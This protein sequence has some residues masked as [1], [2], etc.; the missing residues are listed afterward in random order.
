MKRDGCVHRLRL[1]WTM[2]L[3]DQQGENQQ[4][5]AKHKT[6][7]GGPN[8]QEFIQCDQDEDEIAGQRNEQPGA[9][10]FQ[11]CAQSIPVAGIGS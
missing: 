6:V 11:L 3:D 2:V 5:K 8:R 10:A 1:A 9:C 4:N 7:I